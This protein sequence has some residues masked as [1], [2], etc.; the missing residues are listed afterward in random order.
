VML[1]GV[2][3]LVLAARKDAGL[4]AVLFGNGGGDSA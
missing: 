3:G 4:L 1:V 2:A